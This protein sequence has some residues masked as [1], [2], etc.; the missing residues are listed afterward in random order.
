MFQSYRLACKSIPLVGSSNNTNFELPQRE[1][2]TD[3]F[4]LL[5]PES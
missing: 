4:L 2:A 5:P 3:N 1:I